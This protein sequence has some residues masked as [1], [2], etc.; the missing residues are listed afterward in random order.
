V[1]PSRP[2]SALISSRRSSRQG[3][4][5]RTVAGRVPSGRAR[6]RAVAIGGIAVALSITLPATAGHA[7]P[8]DPKPPSVKDMKAQ[9]AKLDD[10]MEQ[11]TE[12]YNGIR[13][14]LQQAERA[15][16][17]AADNAARQ[18]KELESVQQRVGSLAATSYMNGGLDQTVAFATAQDPQAFLDQ[19][20]TLNYFAT[21]DGT[22]F[23][24]LAAAMQAAQRARK[25]AQ[26]RA[27]E[28][29]A[30]KSQASTQKT[31]VEETYNKLRDKIIKRSPQEIVNIPAV[32]GSGKAVQAL[33]AALTKLGDPYVW[34]AAGPN[35][36][37]CSGLTM[38]AYKQ[39][40][41]NLPH[42]TGSQWNAGTHV[43]RNE[44]QPGDLV[45]FYSDRHHMGMYIGAGKMIHAP[46]TGDV[47]RIAP[48]DGRPFAGAVRVA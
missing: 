14:R 1:E 13:V 19:A 18:Q 2:E 7:D 29:S 36:F 38:W 48:I 47:V 26:D 12:R 8:S 24:T 25:A 9:I 39:V 40:G 15:A 16:K 11:L 17:V 46:H 41:I 27:S 4:A 5:G 33:R 42:F 10:Q 31:K 30:L 43:S 20:S 37:D 22:K 28:L 23:Q 44:L 35:A 6:S 34:G 45:F 21:Q 3:R 32:G